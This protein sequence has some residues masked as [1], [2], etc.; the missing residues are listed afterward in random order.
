MAGAEMTEEI[1][2]MSLRAIGFVRNGVGD[3]PGEEDWWAE[4][5]SELVID[6][7]LTEAL[8]GIEGFSHIIVLFWTHKVKRKESPVKVRPMG[9]REAP[10]VGVFASR[11]PNRPNR[12]GKTTVRLLQRR[13]NILQVE[14]LDALDGTPVLDIKPYI[15]GYDSV[16]DAEVPQWI[17]RR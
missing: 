4:L 16:D 7:S 5:V 13:G 10:V 12:I 3:T 15:P 6:E 11:S 8:D 9:R 1:P 17:T 14:G 2:E